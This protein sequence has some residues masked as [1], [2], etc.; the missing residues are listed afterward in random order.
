MKL[1]PPMTDVSF[2]SREIVKGTVIGPVVTPSELKDMGTKWG[3]P[4]YQQITHGD[5]EQYFGCGN[6]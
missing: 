1:L 4:G 3:E 5:S 6:R 2:I